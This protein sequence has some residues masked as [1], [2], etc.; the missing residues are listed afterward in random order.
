MSIKSHIGILAYFTYGV[1][2]VYVQS[3]N[4]ESVRE[5]ENACLNERERVC[6]G[7]GEDSQ[8][9]SFVQVAE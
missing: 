9:G 8:Y 5:R 2:L 3:S 6:G 1:F 7:G 4:S